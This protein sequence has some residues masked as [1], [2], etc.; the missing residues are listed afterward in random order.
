M[1]MPAKTEMAI[2]A[3]E[4]FA[5]LEHDLGT[6]QQEGPDA[7]RVGAA[8]AKFPA[9]AALTALYDRSTHEV[10]E[11]ASRAWARAGRAVR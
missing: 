6:A 3:D 8:P 7:R 5:K 11:R 2:T 9:H 1:A 10:D 4:D